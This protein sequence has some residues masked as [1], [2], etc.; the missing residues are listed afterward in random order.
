MGGI[1]RNLA[2]KARSFGM[3]IRYYNRSKLSPE[4]EEGAEYVSFENLLKESDVLS[5]NLPLNVSQSPV[6]LF[7][8]ESSQL[9]CL[10][11][12]PTHHLHR[13]VRNDEARSGHRKY[14]TRSR[15]GRGCPGRSPGLGQGS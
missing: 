12:H 2:Q 9:I 15:D 8:P 6:R 10:G 13:P 1:G 11:C 3:R 7:S 14:G 5:L 4:L